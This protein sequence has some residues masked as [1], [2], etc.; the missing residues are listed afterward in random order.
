M[1]KC[2]GNCL[3]DRGRQVSQPQD[4]AHKRWV[5]GLGFG[6]VLDRGMRA[7]EKLAVP[8]VAARDE[9][10]HGVVNERLAALHGA[11]AVGQHDDGQ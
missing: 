10:D 5:Y 4:A 8:A 3:F 6:D 7:V 2:A 9:F 11:L 1:V